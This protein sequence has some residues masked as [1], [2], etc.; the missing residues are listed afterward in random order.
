MHGDLWSEIAKADISVRRNFKRGG[1][2]EKA[3]PV[4]RDFASR[5]RDKEEIRCEGKIQ[6]ERKVSN[7]KD[8]KL[9]AEYEQY[10]KESLA[11]NSKNAARI[12]VDN[13]TSG[14]LR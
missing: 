6:V 12:N 10:L 9:R 3:R 13:E 7:A 8:C 4:R 14:K 2:G 5:R 11:R 1:G